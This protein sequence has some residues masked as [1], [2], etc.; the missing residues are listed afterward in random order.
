MSPGRCVLVT[1]G[2][3]PESSVAVGSDHVTT[4]DGAKTAITVIDPGQLLTIGATRSLSGSTV[5]GIRFV[6]NTSGM[7]NIFT[8]YLY[9]ISDISI[10]L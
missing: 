5:Y 10:G 8:L 3:T 6:C 1:V 7:V 4:A 9:C 2:A